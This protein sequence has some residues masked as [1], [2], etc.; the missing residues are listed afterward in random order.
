LYTY[1]IGGCY[2]TRIQ[3]NAIRDSFVDSI[4]KKAMGEGELAGVKFFIK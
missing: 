1:E 2:L 4:W 3:E